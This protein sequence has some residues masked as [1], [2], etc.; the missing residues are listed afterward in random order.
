MF[1]FGEANLDKIAAITNMQQLMN[2][3]QVHKLTG[4]L[5]T[6]SRFIAKSA[7]KGLPFFKTL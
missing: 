1:G 7:K 3:K 4:R 2:K 5:A 6:L